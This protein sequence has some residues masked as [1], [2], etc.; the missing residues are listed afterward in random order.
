MSDKDEAP[1]IYTK[2]GNLL[3]SELQYHHEWL[4]SPDVISFREWYTLLSTGE[5][6]KDSKHVYLP[7]GMLASGETASM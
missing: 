3:Q 5:I 6:V 1:R 4:V 2:Y 7:K